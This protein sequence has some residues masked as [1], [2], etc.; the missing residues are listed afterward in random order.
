MD[1]VGFSSGVGFFKNEVDRIYYQY[2]KFIL[3][4]PSDL[5][6]LHKA[7]LLDKAYWQAK[8]QRQQAWIKKLKHRAAV[9]KS[10]RK[11]KT[12]QPEKY[13]ALLERKRKNARKRRALSDTEQ[14]KKERTM[15]NRKR[16]QW[17]ID[18]RKERGFKRPELAKAL[19]Y[20]CRALENWEYGRTNIDHH[21]ELLIAKCF[22]VKLECII[23][24][25]MTYLFGPD[26]NKWQA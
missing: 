26:W 18:L 10:Y 8:E 11:M 15:T 9:A 7:W 13:K 12:E 25:E 19:G 24:M 16:R 4:S 22:G 5:K 17:L 3:I 2:R 21:I 14:S 6:R 20:S 23:D 1:R